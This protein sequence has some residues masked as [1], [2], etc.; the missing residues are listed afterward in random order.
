M[1]CSAHHARYAIS[2]VATIFTVKL[3]TI[4]T[5]SKVSVGIGLVLGLV[6]NSVSV[7]ISAMVTP[8]YLSMGPEVRNKARYH[9][10]LA[11]VE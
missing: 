11:E 9:L 8:G 1:E 7:I 10:Y 4:P 5:Q 2:S 3:S 6:S